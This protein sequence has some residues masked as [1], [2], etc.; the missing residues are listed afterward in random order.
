MLEHNNLEYNCELRIRLNTTFY[1]TSRILCGL[2]WEKDNCMISVGLTNASLVPTSAPLYNINDGPSSSEEITN[3][4]HHL[5]SGTT[6]GEAE[7]WRKFTRRA[8]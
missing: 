8:F 2:K 5:N 1:S 6:F 7:S 3:V 4:I